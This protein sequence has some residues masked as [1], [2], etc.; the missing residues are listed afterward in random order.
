MLIAEDHAEAELR[1]ARLTER[2]EALKRR[3]DSGSDVLQRRMDQNIER[4]RADTASAI[5]EVRLSLKDEW[6]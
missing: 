1:L 6:T 3:I 2:H 4:F 5:T